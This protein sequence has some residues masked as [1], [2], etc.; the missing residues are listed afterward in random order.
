[1]VPMLTY[2]AMKKSP[3]H[4]PPSLVSSMNVLGLSNKGMDCV[5]VFVS[6]KSSTYVKTTFTGIV[7]SVVTFSRGVISSAL[8]VYGVC[9]S[10]EDNL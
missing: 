3:I 2:G 1:M 6:P 8:I 5:E 7:Y 9:F 4:I 10:R